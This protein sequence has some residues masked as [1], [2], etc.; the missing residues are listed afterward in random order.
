MNNVCSESAT[1]RVTGLNGNYLN[2]VKKDFS[3]GCYIWTNVLQSQFITFD[4]DL[5]GTQS[6]DFPVFEV[7]E[8]TSIEEP[9]KVSEVIN[10]G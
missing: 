4:L 1:F 9:K 10:E 8:D 7:N 6:L 5:S 3:T 2:S